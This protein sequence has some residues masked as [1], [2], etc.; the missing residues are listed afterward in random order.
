MFA[1]FNQGKK[2]TPLSADTWAR[3]IQRVPCSVIWLTQL[4]Q[5]A[6]ASMAAEFAAR[7]VDSGRRLVLGGFVEGRKQHLRRMALADLFLDTAPFSAG[8][9]GVEALFSST[10]ILTLSGQG[11]T[12]AGRMGESLLRSVGLQ[13][14]VTHT[15][16]VFTHTHACAH[17]HANTHMY[18]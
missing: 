12:F 5:S 4:R 15:R 7:G 13:A 17:T 10:P 18:R 6:H 16:Q 11:A 8:S 1:C 14:L 2:I 3:I 9:V